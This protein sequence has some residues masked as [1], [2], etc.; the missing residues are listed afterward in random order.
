M[1]KRKL[2]AIASICLLSLATLRTC[3]LTEQMWK[4]EFVAPTH[5]QLEGRIDA[6]FQAVGEVDWRSFPPYLAIVATPATLFIDL[7]TAP[8]N[9]AWIMATAGGHGD[10]WIPWF[11][12]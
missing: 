6:P 5:T 4:S 8:I 11:K 2:L 1:G 3:S 9:I 12:R 10:P 7:V